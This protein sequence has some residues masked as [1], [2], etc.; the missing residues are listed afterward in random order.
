MFIVCNFGL[1]IDFER[2]QFQKM[3][4]AFPEFYFFDLP[5]FQELGKSFFNA[6][7]VHWI[8]TFIFTN[9]LNQL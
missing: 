9:F 3:D 8:I 7:K 2:S 1:K 5:L 4:V 6:S